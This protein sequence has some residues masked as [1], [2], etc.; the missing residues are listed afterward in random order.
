MNNI[1]NIEK[2]PINIIT[3]DTL[4]NVDKIPNKQKC[5]DFETLYLKCMKKNDPSHTKCKTEFELWYHCFTP[6]YI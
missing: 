6:L 1:M 4:K 3:I 5:N 2:I